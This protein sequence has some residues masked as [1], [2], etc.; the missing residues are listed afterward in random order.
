MAYQFDTKKFYENYDEK[1]A[2]Q[3]KKQKTY[4]KSQY[5]SS[6]SSTQGFNYG[7]IAKRIEKEQ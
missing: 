2:N 7:S 6:V 5:T 1:V 3:K 4:N